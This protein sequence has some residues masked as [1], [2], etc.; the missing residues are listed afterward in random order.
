MGMGKGSPPAAASAAP[1]PEAPVFYPTEEE[2]ADPLAYVARIRPLAEPYGIC[3]IV[4]PSSWSPPHALDFA[5]LSFPT[6][7]QPIHRLLARPAPA[8]PDTFLLDY[9]RFL[10]AAASSSPHRR[11]G[12]KKAPPKTPALSDGRPLDLC[13]LFHAVKRF[14]GY[15]GTCEGKRWADVVRLVDDKAPVHVSECA[16]HVLAQLYFEH[17]YDYEKFTNQSMPHK[18]KDQNKPGVESSDGQPSVS[19]SQDENSNIS[20]KKTG[21]GG[22]SHGRRYGH[23]IGNNAAP[24]GARKRRRNKFDAAVAVLNG[25]SPAARKRRRRRSDHTDTVPKEE[26]D[27]IC[28]QCSSGLHGDVMLLC[29]RCDKGWHLYCL[30]PP[31]DRVPPG[32]WYCSDCLNS[33]RDCFGFVH[34]RKSCLLDTFRRFDERVRKRWFGQRHPGRLQVEKQFWEIVEG[35]AGELEVMYGSDLDTSIYG[36]G[37]PRLGDPVPSSVDLDM[38]HKYCS[39]PWNL[40]NFPNLRGSVLRTVRDKIAG[41][42]LNV[43]MGYLD[44]KQVPL[45]RK[46]I[47]FLE[48]W[49]TGEN[50]PTTI[51]KT[52]TDLVQQTGDRFKEISK[53]VSDVAAQ[54]FDL[55]SQFAAL[56]PLV[57]IA[58]SLEALPGKRHRASDGSETEVD[59]SDEDDSKSKKPHLKP[60]PSASSSGKD[61]ADDYF[62]PRAK[63]EFPVYDGTGIHCHGSIDARRFSGSNR[64]QMIGALVVP[65]ADDQ[66]IAT[67][68]PQEEP[69]ISIHALTGIH[70]RGQQAMTLRVLIAG[71]Q[72][73]A[74][75][76]SGSTCCFVDST[77]A[78]NLGL[79]LQ[80]RPGL[81]VTVGNGD[82]ITSLGLFSN[83]FFSV[84]SEKFVADFYALPLGTFDAVLGVNWLGSL[85]PILWDFNHHTMVLQRAGRRITWIGIDAPRQ[86][87]LHATI[88][89][90]SDLMPA[91]LE[92]FTDVFQEPQG[93]PPPRATSHR[94]RL[95]ADTEAVAVRH[96]R[97]AHIQ[98]AE[99]EKQC[100]ELLRLGVIQPSSS[101]FSA[102]A[103]LV[104]KKDGSWRLCIDYRALNAKTIKDKFPIPVVEELLDELRGAKFFTKLDLRSGYH[105]VR[106]EPADVHKTAFRTHQGLFEFLV[107][108]FGLSNAPATFQALMNTVLGLFLR[109]FVL[110]FFDDILIYSRS[111]SEHLQHVRTV[112][113]TLREHKLFLRK[114]KCTFGKTSV[115]YLGH[116][117]SAEGVAMDEQKVQAVLQWP[118]PANT[119]ALRGFL[120]LAGYYRRFIQNF[121]VIA[122]PL[123]RLLRKEGFSWSPEADAAFHKLQQALTTALV[124]QLP[125]FEREFVVECDASGSGFGAVLHQGQGAVAFFS[126]QVAP[127]HAKLAAYERELIGLAHA[128]RHWHPYLW[129]REFLVK[130]NH[131]SLKFLLDQRLSTVPQHHWISKLLGFDF[132]VE[133][134]PGAA[135]TVAD[136]LSR[137]DTGDT[138]MALAVSQPA[139]AF[140]DELRTEVAANTA[141]GNQK[142]KADAATDGWSWRDGLLYQGRIFLPASSPTIQLVLAHVHGTGH[143]GIQKTL[144]RFRADFTTPGDRRLITEYVRSCSVC[145]QNK[146][147]CLRPGGLLQPLE[148]PSAVWADIAM[149]FVEAL[150]R[151]NGES[152][153][154]TVVDRFSKFAH[155]I[156]L[157]HPYTATS[158]ARAFFSEIVRLH[159]IPSSIVSD[160][161]PVFTSSFWRELFKLTG[162]KYVVSFSSTVGWPVGGEAKL[163]AVEHQLRDRDE[164]LLDI[165][166]RLEQAQ[167]HMK[168]QADG[169]RREV[170]FQPGDWVMRQA[171]PDL[172]DA[173]PDLL[174][175]LVT[176]LNPSI[177]RANG[178]PVYSV[179]QEPGNFVITFP[180]SF[181]GGFNLGLNCAEAVNFAP[182]DWLPHG[183]IGADLYRLYRKAPVLSHEELL[184]VVAKNGVDAESLPHLKGEIERLFIKERRLREELWVNGIVKSSSMLPRS[185]PNFIGSE[186][187]PTCIICR[188]YLYLSAVSCNCRLSSYVC[189]EHWK[190]LCE[191]SPEKHCLLYRHTLAELGDLVCEVSLASRTRDNVKQNLHLLNDACVPSK[192]VNDQYISYAQL[193]EDWVSKSEHILQIPFLER[194]YTTALEEAEQF[195]WGDHAMDSVRNIALKLTEAMNWALGVRKCLSKIEDFLK[196]GCSEKINYVE[197]EELI[198][199]KCIPCCEPSLSK[200]QAYAEEGKTLINE[201]N[202]A[203]SSCLTVDKLEALYSRVS[204]FPVKL[205]E[206]STLFQEISSAKSWL[207]K[208]SDCLEHNKLGTIDIDSLNKLKLE[209]IQLRVLLPEADLVSKMWK[210]AESWQMRCQLY[211][212]DFP[213]LKELESFLLAVDGAKF[214]IPELN[215]LKQRYSVDELA[216]VEKEL[217]R[218]LCR[219]Q[220][221]EALATEM[222]MDAIE[223]VL[224]EASILTIEEE[225]PFVDLS[226]IL[227]EATAWE[228]KA[229]II[230]EQSAS[231]SEYE[232]HMRRSEEIRVIL[233]SEFHM[234]AEIDNAKLWIDKCQV[235]LRPRCNRLAFGE[236]LKVDDIK[237]LIN[238]SANLK[239]ILDA[240]ALNSVLNNVEKWE[241]TSL[242]LLN[243]LRTLLHL[244]GIGSTVDPLRKNL[245]ELQDKMNKE[246]ESGSSLGF[247]FRIL[248]ELKDSLLMLRWIL[249]SLS[250]CCM[251]PLLQD[252][253]RLIE[254][255]AHLPVSLSDCSLVTL[256]MRALSCLRKALTLLP[257]PE[258][259]VKSKLQDVENILA[260]FKEIDVPYPMMTAKLEDAVDKHNSWTEQCNIF[261]MS[262]DDQSWARLLS[263][264]DNG[265]SVAFDCPE[266][267]KVVVEVKKVEEWLNQCHCALFLD[268]NTSS[269]LLPTLIKI[270]GSLDGVCTLYGEDCMKK[271]FCATCSCDMMGDSM[272]S[273]CVTCQDWYHDSCME[274]L[275]AS[276]QMKSEW[277][278]PFCSLLQSEDLLE[279]EIYVKVKM[280]KGNRPTLTA[281]TELVFSAK[282]FYW[283]IEEINLLEEIVE[284]A[285]NINAYLMQIL[286]DS[287]SYHGEDLT[288]I[289]KSLLIALKVTSASGL[290]NHYVSC[291]VESV[292]GRYLWK[293]QI[294]KLLCGGKKTSIQEVLRLD[295]EGSHLEICGEDFFKLEISKIKEASLRWMTKAEKVARDSGELA[296]DLVYGL[297]VEGESLSVHFEKELKLLRDRSV[298]YCICRKPYDNRAMIACDQCD[299][300][301][302][303]DCINLLGPPPETYFC[304]ACHPN[305]GE[306]CISLARPDDDE[307][308]YGHVTISPAICLITFTCCAHDQALEVDLTLPQHLAVN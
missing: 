249:D 122:E 34:R 50:L 24:D 308:R 152:V 38:W 40:N 18:E 206:S 173:Q 195:L 180:R 214:S 224:N 257:D 76:D 123:T 105:Q 198:V 291:K 27:Q 175:H 204:D 149:D 64:H 254:A 301:Y 88:L 179:T 65:D 184:Y 95:T 193:A 205:T 284:K 86:A 265:Q 234:K 45:R 181:H 104:R 299:E 192:K 94:I 212:Q 135:N 303:F 278:C 155:F 183:G 57:P 298:L 176:M 6:K 49:P 90:D 267:D 250:L 277:I 245:E 289:Y 81:H 143:E 61:K 225:Q 77:V 279:N 42:S 111:W 53:A 68:E 178:V 286:D 43:G 44:Q 219:K 75:I 117:I 99:L 281:L 150:P 276:P 83:L 33:D 12:R 54:L 16:K 251:I 242:S 145:Q 269:C 228:E 106:M 154:L 272:T 129:G 1:V 256:L 307:D 136:A 262:P 121:G 285:C 226:R 200:L 238:Q 199:I 13:R 62:H 304:P 207:K 280:C 67:L 157:A 14:G 66:A 203:L 302:H 26:V 101:A 260:E 7:R 131:R 255:A 305:N 96:Y 151:I 217:K 116:V 70:A 216:I 58:K 125:D 9:R 174:F 287:Y 41:V 293:K 188:Q 128:L 288:V 17:L 36:S 137:R 167:Q 211:L 84:G 3:R 89:H 186:E 159:G 74:L 182:A 112:L 55:A 46:S 208:A 166:G 37:F 132:R 261:F 236:T 271:R 15:D 171:L 197:I 213:G 147:D 241:H 52:L 306:E 164:F 266:M 243:N 258:T 2:F 292:L 227:K 275:L 51:S 295:E 47:F 100:A 48:N 274:N 29:D 222:Y 35:K 72:L 196:D 11:R 294:H 10:K 156:P 194:S 273:R 189:L 297:I 118:T 97:Y 240:S 82:Q 139:F 146:I 282:G 172:F 22:K 237:G 8:D 209:I 107:M 69:E 263:L 109:K 130:T 202:I 162:T 91:L 142:A 252:V 141:L 71:V 87:E 23:V 140:Y 63:L 300:W 92:E 59:S 201:V 160:R 20:D 124:L 134:R 56:E 220:A 158:V 103:L 127:R 163:P 138:I 161:D 79:A 31:L 165:R 168:A 231:L 113:Q 19:G 133:Y 215:L 232:D 108:P 73:I 30:S 4:P 85:G 39:N 153:I 270:R 218:S 246:I 110:V 114:S 102:P 235:Y 80:Q 210:D 248:Y 144:H 247:E 177:L 32:N 25:A 244:N 170:I 28:E 259:S 120:G 78:A 233:P 229:R 21:G 239:V 98:K 221:Y 191:C 230:L 115:V 283:G 296:L 190:H 5:S 60:P 268:G 126:Q 93:L 264:R 169:A 187:D 253:D 185:N 223:E 290:Y 148:V 119:R